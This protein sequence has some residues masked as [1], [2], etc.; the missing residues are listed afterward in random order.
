[1][2]CT[3][4]REFN[5]PNKFF[6]YNYIYPYNVLNTITAKDCNVTF[7]DARY[8]NV[9]ENSLAGSYPLDYNFLK[10]KP[11]Y[12]IGMSVPPLMTAKIA[13]QNL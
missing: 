12:L 8:L 1:M 9:K 6:S 13:E 5:K 7:R 2:S 3:Q 11:H 4:D 10:I